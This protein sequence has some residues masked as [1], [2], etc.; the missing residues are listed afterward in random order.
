MNRLA[1]VFLLV[2]L[3]SSA[4]CNRDPNKSDLDHLQGYWTVESHIANGVA[5]NT[6]GAM[7]EIV[8]STVFYGRHPGPNQPERPRSKMRLDATKNPKEFDFDSF[9]DNP[10]GEGKGSTGIYEIDGDTVKICAAKP[11][12]PR[13]TSFESNP[14]SGAVYTVLKR[15]VAKN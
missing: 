15:W 4:G 14:G 10:E 5:S 8:G 3:V 9:S 11:G 7:W 6:D 13:P 1:C 2:P 12:L